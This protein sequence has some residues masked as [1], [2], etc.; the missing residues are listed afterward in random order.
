MLE[1]SIINYNNFKLFFNILY[2][3]SYLNCIKHTSGETNNQ[4][5]N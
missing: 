2:N 3:K 5:A 4:I 1:I